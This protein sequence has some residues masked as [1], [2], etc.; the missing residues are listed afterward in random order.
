MSEEEDPDDSGEYPV[1]PPTD[2]E[3][4]IDEIEEHDEE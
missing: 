4:L 2:H 3:E 1:E